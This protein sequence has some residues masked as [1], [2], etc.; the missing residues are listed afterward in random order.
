MY[1]LEK[2]SCINRY[3]SIGKTTRNSYS[4][5]SAFTVDYQALIFSPAFRRLLDKAQLFPLEQFDYVRTRLTHSIEV[6]AISEEI[7]S[8][9][10]MHMPELKNKKIAFKEIIRYDFGS[11]SNTFIFSI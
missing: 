11:I 1:E 7:I 10:C 4:N 3:E 5:I 8:K 6:E 2:I 9:V